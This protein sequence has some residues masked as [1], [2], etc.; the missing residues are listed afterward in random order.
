MIKTETRYFE[1]LDDVTPALV[2]QVTH[3]V[4]SYMLWVGPTEGRAE[5][6]ESAPRNGCLCR[7]WACAMPPVSVCAL[8]QY[9]LANNSH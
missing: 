2:I 9:I 1:P 8:K 5:D 3:L 4:D 6:A 7:D